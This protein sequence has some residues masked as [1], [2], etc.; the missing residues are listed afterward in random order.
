MD[1][2]ELFKS[3][4]PARVNLLKHGRADSHLFFD[5][6]NAAR[7]D[8]MVEQA[9]QHGIYLKIVSDEKS[10]GIRNVIKSDGTFGKYGNNNFYAANNTKGRWMDEA[11]SRYLTERLGHR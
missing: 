1:D 8:M 7:W 9:E 2:V 4:D 5:D 10:E 11:S 3:D 6:L